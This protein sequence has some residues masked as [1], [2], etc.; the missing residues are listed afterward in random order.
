[1]DINEFSQLKGQIL[2]GVSGLKPGSDSVVF[3]LSDGRRFK[4]FHSQDCCEHVAIADVNGD[5][6]DLIG[7]PLWLCEESAHGDAPGSD[8]AT[9]TFYRM[10]TS[11][12][13][14]DIR[15]VGESNG[16]YSESVEFRKI[17]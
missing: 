16:Y 14:V 4:L 5:E 17:R 1:M 9:W 11:K 3:E 15:W 12:G 13:Y 2:V 10:A 7:S 6:T 8:S